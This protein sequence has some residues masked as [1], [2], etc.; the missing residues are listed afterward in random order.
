MDVGDVHR[1]VERVAAIDTGCADRVA[2]EAAVGE[3]RRLKSWVESREVCVARA[4]REVSSF[5]EKNLADA[6][7][8]N[9]RDAERVMRRAEAVEASPAFEQAL[10]A[11]RVSGEH[12]DAFDRALRQLEPAARQLLADQAPRLAQVAEVS[13][14]EEFAKTL[15]REA[16]RLDS[17]ADAEAR[18]ARQKTQVRMHSWLERDTGMGRWALHWDPETMLR[19]ENAV[20]AQLEALFHDTTPDGCPTD[21][22]EKQAFLRAHALL[23][24]IDGNGIRLG[25]PEVVVVVDHTQPNPDGTPHIDWDLPVELPHRVLHDLAQRAVVHEVVIRNGVIVSAPGKLDLGRSSRT[26]NRAQRRALHALYPSCA[27]PGCRVRYSR[28]RLHHV[29]FWHH[30]GLTDLANL[31]PVC[32]HH[33][34][35]IHQ[36][37]WVMALAFDRTLTITFPDGRVMT[38]G[39]P[40]RNAA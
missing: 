6:S 36:D 30:L 17:D 21:L 18:L 14:V 11:G 16:R 19:L 1:L 20:D 31:L 9:L 15:R 28:T 25:R 38:T 29:R 40:Q 34:Q 4:L 27:I 8:T 33:H 23:A 10:N 3:L 12:V 7:R 13:S 35:R 2:L 5:P 22:L 32:E 37:G 24:I 39:P 26:A